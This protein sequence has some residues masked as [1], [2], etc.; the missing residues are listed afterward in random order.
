MIPLGCDKPLVRKPVV[1][2][3]IAVVCIIVFFLTAM[4]SNFEDIVVA[5]GYVP[6]HGSILTLFT[7][8]FMHADIAHLLGNLIFFAIAG[9]KMEDALGHGKFLLFY[10]ACGFAAAFLHEILSD[11]NPVPYIGAS[12][13]IAGVL[14]GFMVLYP[15]SNVRVLIFVFLTQVPAWFVHGLW[16]L[17]ELLKLFAAGEGYTLGSGVA[18]AAHV[19]GFAT[20]AIWA[21]A[22]FGWN[23]GD[24]LDDKA[25]EQMGYGS[26]VAP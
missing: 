20:G 22:Y 17:A 26:Y 2:I 1:T 9:I 3:G 5:Y 7:S 21:W 18:F 19:G 13:A 8:M 24:A 16:F 12:G 6:G 23:Q 10:L 11:A 25:Y 4:S 15:T 14:G